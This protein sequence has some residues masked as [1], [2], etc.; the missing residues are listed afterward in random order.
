MAPNKAHLCLQIMPYVLPVLISVSSTEK[1]AT[2]NLYARRELKGALLVGVHSR[3]DILCSKSR[4]H[5][6]VWGRQ[7]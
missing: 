6:F 7:N 2:T 1:Q 4:E 5:V 3:S